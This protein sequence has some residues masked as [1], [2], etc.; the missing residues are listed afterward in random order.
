MRGNKYDYD[1][2]YRGEYILRKGKE[3]K[4]FDTQS[5]FYDFLK[6]LL[7]SLEGYLENSKVDQ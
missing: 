1:Q 3:V 5:E 6:T 4:I 7:P 2:N